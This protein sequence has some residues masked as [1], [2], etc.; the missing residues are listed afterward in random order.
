MERRCV[1]WTPV[2]QSRPLPRLLVALVCVVLFATACGDGGGDGDAE[3]A[4]S[5][6]DWPHDFQAE[7][8]GGGTFD[9]G[10]YEGQDLVLWFW[11]PW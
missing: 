10:D 11:A 1:S 7:L 8:I 4:A 2:T 3:Q 6:G 9:A 5:D